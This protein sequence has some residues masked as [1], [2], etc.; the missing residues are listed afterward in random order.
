[1]DTNQFPRFVTVRDVR[2]A[3]LSSIPDEMTDLFRVKASED[4]T[5]AHLP[6]NGHHGRTRIT[7]YRCADCTE[8][9]GKQGERRTLMNSAAPAPLGQTRFRTER[10]DF[11]ADAAI[12]PALSARFEC[13]AAT[14]P[15]ECCSVFTSPRVHRKSGRICS[16]QLAILA[17]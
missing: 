17:R 7:K 8:R 3:L 2:S 14:Y 1:M 4:R 9:D 11:L 6:V 13:W 5:P 15:H 10:P 12:R 16:L